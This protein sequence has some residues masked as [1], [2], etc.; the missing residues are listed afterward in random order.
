MTLMQA[1]AYVIATSDPYH[2]LGIGCAL[3]VLFA[4]SALLLARAY[5]RRRI[6]RGQLVARFEG[7]RR[8]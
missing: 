5:E 2:L 3:G 7:D 1:I 4:S 8:V 6:G